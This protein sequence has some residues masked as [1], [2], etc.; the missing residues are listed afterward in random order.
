MSDRRPGQRRGV[1]HAIAHHRHLAV[2]RQQSLDRVDLLFGQQIRPD[3]VDPGL[4]RNRGG[5][6]LTLSPVS[7]TVCGCPHV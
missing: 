3:L 5:R 2:L 7:M 4:A 1:V 6:A